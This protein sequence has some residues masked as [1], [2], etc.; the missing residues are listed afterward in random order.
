MFAKLYRM[1]GKLFSDS[2]KK[3]IERMLIYAN[4]GIKREEWI[5]FLT[6]CGIL[7]GITVL[8]ICYR[9]DLL[10]IGIPL[11][12]ASLF[13]TH[14][15]SHLSLLMIATS[16]GKFVESILPDA[17]ML[18]ASNMRSGMTAERAIFMSARPEF[19]PL[20]KEIRDAGSKIMAGKRVDKVL[21]DIPNRIKSDLLK[22]TLDLIIDGLRSGGEFAS[23]LE[24][25]AS[26]IRKAEIL[27]REVRSNVMM[28]VIF[29]F[30]AAG[31]GAPMLFGI[32]SCLVETIVKIGE[33]VEIP[34]EAALVGMPF[35]RLG[36]VKL[37]PGMLI[38]FSVACL[39]IISLF[40]GLVI[41]LI[42]KG[43]E[44]YGLKYIPFLLGLSLGIFFATRIII[45]TFII[46]VA[47]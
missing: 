24:E 7:L 17:L 14:L 41:G 26:D 30:F 15:I 22:R 38:Y 16:R 34:E 6:L 39:F 2:Y 18:M 19:G 44:K 8:A 31:I 21:A 47:I 29:I 12:F 23:L 3:E 35:V 33:V 4:V 43:R 20:E 32:S 25:V 28:Y 36:I 40:G 42:E 46:A 10:P 37:P 27:Q 1:C 45:T 11:A 13:A 9:L 5:G